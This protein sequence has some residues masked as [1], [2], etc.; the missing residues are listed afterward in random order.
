MEGTRSRD[1]SRGLWWA[2][3]ILILNLIDGVLTI[4]L[5]HGGLATEANPLM[6]MP[7]M[8]WGPTGF[9]VIKLSLVSLGV[10]LLWRYRQRR[11]AMFALGSLAAV[12]CVL[13]LYHVRSVN[14]LARYL[15]DSGVLRLG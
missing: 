7:L 11:T 13:A 4:A 1:V 9:M 12:Y 3:V 5:V 10:A 14:V 15:V 6:E 2:A 8:S